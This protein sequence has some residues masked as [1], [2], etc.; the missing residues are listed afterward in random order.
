M[1]SF[2]I[3]SEVDMQEVDNAV[4]QAAKEISTRFDFRGSNTKV[5]LDKT[6]KSIMI[7]DGDEI[8]LRSVH[9]ILESKMVKRGLDLR[10]LDYKDKE[11]ASGREV[12]QTLLLKEGIEKDSAKVITKKIKETK[13][14]VQAQIQDQQVRV[15]G[16]KIDDLQDVIQMLKEANVDFPLQFI[17][18]RT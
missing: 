8:K 3:V 2:D 14:K 18:M 15:T 12:R 10:I 5:Q 9:T 16:K 11:E 4:N 17:N 7:H 13:L 1:P 6:K